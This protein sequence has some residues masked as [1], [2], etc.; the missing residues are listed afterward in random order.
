[1]LLVL[2]LVP[3][4]VLRL[5]LPL[6][7]LAFIRSCTHLQHLQLLLTLLQEL[8]YPALLRNAFVVPESI[9]CSPF[10]V[11]AEVVSGEL[12]A[13]AQQRAILLSYQC[14]FESEL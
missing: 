7:P 8:L 10:G 3:R 12:A 14:L 4:L 9:A 2:R 5:T 6:D 1:M 11:L 13:L